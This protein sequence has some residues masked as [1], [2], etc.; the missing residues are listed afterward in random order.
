M[1]DDK[2]RKQRKE[3]L[4]KAIRKYK[5]RLE[6]LNSK[7]ELLKEWLRQNRVAS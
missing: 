3:E 2:N 5:P 1:G 4:D 7:I 6:K